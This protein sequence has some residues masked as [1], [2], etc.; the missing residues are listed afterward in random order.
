MKMMGRN[1]KCFRSKNIVAAGFSI[2]KNS[3]VAN[4]ELCVR[5]GTIFVEN[6]NTNILNRISS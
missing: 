4:D 3:N 5:W 1:L 6:Y 2:D